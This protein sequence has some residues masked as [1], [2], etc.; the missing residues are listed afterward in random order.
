MAFR[1]KPI[2]LLG[3]SAAA[4]PAAQAESPPGGLPAVGALLPAQNPG[5]LAGDGPQLAQGAAAQEP[6]PKKPRTGS[7]KEKT[8]RTARKQASK[9]KALTQEEEARLAL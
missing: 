6:L 1:G 9:K 5:G 7:G 4:A 8:K 2:G 3:H